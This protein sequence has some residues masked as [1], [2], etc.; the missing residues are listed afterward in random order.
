METIKSGGRVTIHYTDYGHMEQVGQLRS[1]GYKEMVMKVQCSSFCQTHNINQE[2]GAV[3]LDLMMKGITLLG[4]L[5]ELEKI[6]SLWRAV[7]GRIKTV[8]C[9]KIC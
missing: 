6:I 1:M 8:S 3:R 5:I 4:Q 7:M 2:H 9:W